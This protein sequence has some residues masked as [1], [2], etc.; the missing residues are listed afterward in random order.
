MGEILDIPDHEYRALSA[1]NISVL[2]EARR[3]M[4]HVK[5]ARDNSQVDSPSKQLGR[6][7]HVAILEPEELTRRYI[8]LPPILW[9]S[10]ANKA[11]SIGLLFEAGVFGDEDDPEALEKLKR[12]E[13]DQV[14]AAQTDKE[15]VPAETFMSVQLIASSVWS[16]PTAKKLLEEADLVEKAM[17]WRDDVLGVKCKGKLDAFIS[18]RGFLIDFK[19]TQDASYFGFRRAV[20]KFD[21]AAQAAH[22]RNGLRAAGYDVNAVIFIAQETS[23]PYGT[24][25]YVLS[26]ESINAASILVSDWLQKWSACEVTG[27]WPGYSETIQDMDLSEGGYKRMELAV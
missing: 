6:I 8:A 24:A 20:E 5:H 3:S 23:A 1:A 12:D 17:V 21:Y 27:H 25:V 13:L 26:Q 18:K 19:T 10:K 11:R 16:H 9:N 7:Q 22:Y 2:K 14:I 4:A 15:I